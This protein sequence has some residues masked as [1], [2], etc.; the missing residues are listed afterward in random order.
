M[1]HGKATT[2]S[3]LID[4]KRREYGLDWDAHKQV[5]R[6]ACINWS[7]ANQKAILHTPDMGRVTL[8]GYI[9]AYHQL[10]VNPEEIS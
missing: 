6:K 1:T 10:Y 3:Q 7:I 2:L 9:K 5:C 8:E 4:Q